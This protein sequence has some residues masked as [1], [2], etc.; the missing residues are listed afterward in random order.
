MLATPQGTEKQRNWKN[1]NDSHLLEKYEPT[2]H[3]WDDLEQ[4]SFLSGTRHSLENTSDKDE[5]K[6]QMR[7]CTSVGQQETSFIPL[8]TGITCK[9]KPMLI[10]YSTVVNK[11]YLYP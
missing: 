11:V 2:D 4:N 3:H 6:F 10:S 9:N 7:K 8:M 1:Y 5:M